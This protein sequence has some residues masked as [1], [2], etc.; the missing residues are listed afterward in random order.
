M[1][2]APL[3]EPTR[4]GDSVGR[5]DAVL[6]GRFIGTLDAALESVEAKVG[7]DRPACA[8]AAD[9]PAHA[10]VRSELLAAEEDPSGVRS[11]SIAAPPP[12]ALDAAESGAATTPG[13]GPLALGL[14]SDG[15]AAAGAGAAKP[16][17]D[18]ELAAYI[19]SLA[20]EHVAGGLEAE[21]AA[22]SCSLTRELAAD[23][24]PPHMCAP[25]EPAS[26]LPS[27]QPGRCQRDEVRAAHAPMLACRP[28]GW[29]RRRHCDWQAVSD[30]ES[31]PEVEA[32]LEPS[33]LGDGADSDAG[34]VHETC[35][36]CGS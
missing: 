16:F 1:P 33:D 8:A 35:G 30:V 15:A 27:E 18:A 25:A 13:Q 7:S 10:S 22:D 31:L 5:A 14:P 24:P 12:L 32:R 29:Q 23:D 3:P 17:S 26:A 34:S 9:P 28:L 11:G 6:M 36:I 20:S 19:R 4:V 21:G 2:A